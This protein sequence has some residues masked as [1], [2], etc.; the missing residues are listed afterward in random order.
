MSGFGGL[1]GLFSVALATLAIALS[2]VTVLLQRRQHQR[3]AYRNTYD[4]L[5]SESLHRGRWLIVG[6]G[7]GGTLP[8]DPAELR[9]M[10]RTLGT[11]DN[12]AMYV[13]HRVVPRDWV[14]EVWHHPLYQAI[15]DLE[16][17]LGIQQG[18][19]AADASGDAERDPMTGE[20]PPSLAATAVSP[21]A[22]SGDM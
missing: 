18:E 13:R 4:V 12:L 11:F 16:D 19:V 8:D 22:C 6:L 9:L 1:E 15:R 5:M 17:R 21:R 3:D 20:S 2:L 7:D 14:L 10:Y